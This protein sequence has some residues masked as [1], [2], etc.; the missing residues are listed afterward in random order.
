MSAAPRLVGANA[1]L[2]QLQQ[3]TAAVTVLV[4]T[5]GVVAAG[6]TAF[7]RPVGV[8]DLVLFATFY[9]VSMV[10]TCV[11]YHRLFTHRS[12]E[13]PR[14]L[15][16]LLVVAGS[17]AG[18]GPVIF[19]VATHRLHHQASDTPADPH[20]PV[21][22]PAGR[23]WG[24]LR[25]FLH[26]HAGWMFT[27]LAVNP[28]KYAPDLIKD[29]DMGR[30]NKRYLPYLALG[31][32]VPALL[33]ALWIGG[34]WGA[35]EGLLW[36]GLV[37]MF[38]AQHATWSVNS[39]CHVWGARP[40]ATRDG[41]RNNAWLALPT[42]GESWHNN[43]HAHPSSALHGQGSWQV[44]PSGLLIRALARVGVVRDLKLPAP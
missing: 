28:L 18:E 38:A 10:G 22:P 36:G 16:H 37:R 15:R 5:L 7:V 9:V 17:I 41:S 12:F 32:L 2:L 42:L 26:A 19:W 24:A 27:E 30:W 21:V 43:H 31:L 13:A 34:A 40:H 8:A 20:S 35:W 1:R 23:P 25:T 33:G 44:D 6:A 39:L 11:G 3:R 14:W 29:P 4:P